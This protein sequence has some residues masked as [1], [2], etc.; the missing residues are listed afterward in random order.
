VAFYRQFHLDRLHSSSLDGSRPG[1]HLARIPRR[2]HIH[3]V[4]ER[5]KHD[6]I[7][8]ITK[9]SRRL[10]CVSRVAKVHK[11]HFHY[12]FYRFHSMKPDKTGSC[13]LLIHYLIVKESFSLKPFEAKGYVMR[14]M[15]SSPKIE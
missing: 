13:C 3:F 5:R 14:R 15:I 1:F 8:I 2:S 9:Q 10:Y 4:E 11:V 6:F 12:A 7:W